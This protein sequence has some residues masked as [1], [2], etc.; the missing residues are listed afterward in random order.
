MYNLDS[1]N[2]KDKK[3]LL[4]VDFNVPLSAGAIPTDDTRIRTALPTIQK[5]LSEGGSII[6]LTHRGRP[7]G[8]RNDLRSLKHILPMVEKLTGRN[9]MFCEDVLSED[10][11]EI[12]KNLKP[13]EIM[14]LENLRFYQ[15]ELEADEEFAKKLSKL[16]D[17]YVNDAFGTAH[18]NHASTATIAKYFPYDK[19]FGYL[20]ESEMKTLGKLVKD[21]KS[22]FTL[23]IGGDKVTTKIS[24][25]EALLPK[26][27][28]L[29]VGGGILYTFAKAKGLE[30]GDSLLEAEYID[31]AK[32]ILKKAN[33]NNVNIYLAED[34]IIADKHSNDANIEHCKL[35][36][37]KPGWR[38]L[39]IGYKSADKF[40]EIINESKT[41]LWDGPMG[42]YE[43]SHYSYGTQKIALSVARATD[44]GL[45][46]VVGGGDT[47]VALNKYSLAHKIS[48][49][50]TA[51]G[52]LLE[53]FEGKKLPSIRAI[54]QSFSVDDYNFY[55]K[56]VLMRVDFNVP[57]DKNFNITDDTR[58][59][60]AIPTIR[61]ILSD[62]G[63]VIL[64][65]HIGRPKGQF[66][67]KYSVKHIVPYLSK[68]FEQEVKFPGDCIG[69]EVTKMAKALKPREVMIL[70]NLRFYPEEEKNEEKF[71]KKLA[72]LGDAY[73][74]NAFGTAHRAHASTYMVAKFF[75]EDKMLGYLV[76]SEIN[77][78]DRVLF[79]GE[80]PFTAIIGGS[81]VSTK[82][83][84]IRAL[85][86][87]VDSL[88]I[89]GGIAFTF[90][91]AMGGHVGESL[92]EEDYIDVAKDIL[93]KAVRSNVKL[94]LP[95]DC[96]IADKFD[97]DANIKHVKINQIP[98][99]WM[100]LD[101]GIKS[102]ETFAKVIERSRTLLWNGPMGVFEFEHFC[103]G[104][105]KIALSVSRS[106]DFGAFSLVGGG[107]SIAAL[108]KYGLAHKI[109]Y[110]STAGG[111]LL[112]YIE[113]KELP[114]LK[115][116]RTKI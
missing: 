79:K 103:N 39:D 32:R 26:I 107:D 5:I 27:D 52:A 42:A 58:I 99:G 16:G 3:V 21:A 87:K 115:A 76:E 30:I 80:K 100:G 90:I 111:A 59:V 12:A 72:S 62:G 101:I 93:E 7:K 55:N 19:M 29:L 49:L 1:Y 97:P 45:Y 83:D 13:G 96:I 94:Y 78:I 33:E 105:I 37:I 6:I 15:E 109:S 98:D 81:K 64:M 70:E 86:S 38:G 73:I 114:S 66:N 24:I 88:I 82:I 61:K 41:V 40:A 60:T 84:I 31:V 67:E 44:K 116:I 10:T 36:E 104:T 71:A 57:L 92:V 25:V 75:P 23:I 95:T 22:P 85:M 63:S 2:F 9:I 50:S 18:R 8:Q 110:V 48:Y 46:S 112:E 34:C 51:G 47:I 65:T 77:N 54:K 11:V 4:R 28:N 56:K 102:A 17:V 53:F 106:T 35:D 74:M 69:S 108:N 20:F 43:M 68:L 91:K 14:M 113:G 89:G